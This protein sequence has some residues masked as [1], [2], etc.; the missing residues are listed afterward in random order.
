MYY[1]RVTQS[2]PLHFVKD[3]ERSKNVFTLQP[4]WVSHFGLS[5]SIKAGAEQFVAYRCYS[6]RSKDGQIIMPIIIGIL[7]LWSEWLWSK[8]LG[9]QNGSDQNG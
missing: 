7:Y 4:L 5:E 8:W 9:D 2:Q 6:N 1:L 3:M